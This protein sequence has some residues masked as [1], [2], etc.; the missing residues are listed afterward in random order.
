MEIERKWLV[1]G[2]PEGLAPAQ[3]YQMAQGYLALRHTTVRI[4]RETAQDGGTAYILC[5]K[6]RGKLVREEIETPIDQALF[7]R[8]SL[9]IGLPL[10]QK[11]RRDYPLPDGRTLE[12]NLVDA[13]T[14][15]AFFYAEVEFESEADA[16]TWSAADCGLAAYLTDEV[17]E[18]SGVSMGAYWQRT[19]YEAT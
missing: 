19:R 14:P 11:E 7:S 10:I 1:S 9:L 4:R 16:R 8:L 18:K 3:T 6:G 15:T 5:F 2:W 13:G 12:V 17:T